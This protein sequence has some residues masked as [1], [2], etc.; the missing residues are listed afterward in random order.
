MRVVSSER[1]SGTGMRLPRGRSV[2]A[3]MGVGGGGQNDRLRRHSP[4]FVAAWREI[5]CSVYRWR[6]EGRFAVVPSLLGRSVFSYLPGLG[7][8]DLA[9]AEAEALAREMRGRAFNIRV[10]GTLR[11]EDAPRPGSSVVMRL[12]L[13]SFGHDPASVW[14]DALNRKTR[15]EVR[16]ARRAGYT[17]SEESGPQAVLSLA[18]VLRTVL[19]RHGAPS[20]PAALFSAVA[21]EMGG[22]ILVV[23]GPGGEVAA[24]SLSLRDGPLAFVPWGGVSDRN[25]G[26]GDLGFWAMVEQAAREGADVLDWGSCELESGAFRFKQKFGAAPS[27]VSR[28]SHRPGNLY[29]RYAPAQRLFRALP[30]A[31]SGRLGPKL[32]RY[33][34]DY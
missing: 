34:A 28:L 26:V 24:A 1:S 25:W 22:R 27:P 15:W 32:C 17:V 13:A 14:R 18:A 33:L 9:P 16:R 29:R 6:Q 12:D 3:C 19:A 31:V 23:R 4:E 5:Y 21:R 2:D 8:T 7:Y 10:F 20:P 30:G 11:R